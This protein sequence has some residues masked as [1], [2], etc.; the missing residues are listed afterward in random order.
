MAKLRGVL[1][2]KDLQKELDD[3]NIYTS[4]NKQGL[5]IYS[6]SKIE[7]M[8]VLI[9]RL[10]DYRLHLQTLSAR[11]RFDTAQNIF[12]YNDMRDVA[13]RIYDWVQ[14]KDR[15]N[16][17]A[18]L[19]CKREYMGLT[20][21]YFAQRLNMYESAIRGYESGLYKYRLNPDYILEIDKAK[22]KFDKA[23]I[24]KTE[25][26]QKLPEDERIIYV[27]AGAG[28]HEKDDAGIPL[29]ASYFRAMAY[30]INRRVKFSK[31]V[32]KMSD[33]EEFE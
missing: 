17:A 10:G 18:L 16:P 1:Q 27:Y 24:R 30:Q 22:N 6:W 29:P 19:R 28:T 4:L 12:I 20:K 3:R 13:Q 7:R 14:E 21:H 9:D 23:I 2:L 31:I 33:V 11:R 8:K 25:K 5:H 32:Y 15:S 26:L